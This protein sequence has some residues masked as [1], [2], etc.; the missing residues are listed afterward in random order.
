MRKISLFIF[1]VSIFWVACSSDEFEIQEV[2]DN[3]IPAN[4]E[5]QLIDTFTVRASTFMMD[6]VPTS[7][8]ASMLVGQYNDTNF[9]KVKSVAYAKLKL[10]GKFR[11]EEKN[12]PVFDSIVFISYYNRYYYGDTT[13]MQTISFHRVSEEMKRPKNNI[14]YNSDSFKYDEQPLG[15]IQFKAE[16]NTTEKRKG[17]EDNVKSVPL[18]LRIRLNDDFGKH[19]MEL[20]LQNSDTLVEQKMFEEMMPGFCLVPN[21]DDDAAIIGLYPYARDN[22]NSRIDTLTKVR[23]YYHEERG[24]SPNTSKK[25]DLKLGEGNYIFNNIVSDRA[26]TPLESLALQKEDISS[27]LTADA[28]YVQGGIG[29]K[30]KLEI[31]YL[32]NLYQLGVTGALLKAELLMFP[33]VENHGNIMYPLPRTFTLSLCDGRNRVISVLSS[34]KNAEV[35]LLA[36]LIVEQ[37]YEEDYYYSFDITNFVNGV[38]ANVY[39]EETQSLIVDLNAP[40]DTDSVNRVIFYN[41][42]TNSKRK[43]KIKATYVVQKSE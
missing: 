25:F 38:L 39:T 13:K 8:T 33:E 42:K 40:A 1:I 26:G 35:P 36:E 29:V 22:R 3:F 16:P 24:S 32:R 2:G 4:T 11:L 5:V 30:T 34:P 23:L 31:P 19:L 9:G 41:S 6:S 12:Q 10:G 14:F 37:Q 43:F 20:A 15:N 7:N 27:E 21:A 17:E 28:T 18:D